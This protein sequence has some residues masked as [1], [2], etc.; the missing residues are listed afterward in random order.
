MIGFLMALAAAQAA[1]APASDEAL[2]R[3][4]IALVQSDPP[5][6]VSAANDWRM[7]GG[8]IHAR[9]CLALAYAAQEQWASAATV[10]EQA[11]RDAEAARDPRQADFWVQAGNAWIAAQDNKK[12][13]TALDAAL[14]TTHLTP[15]LRGETLLDRARASV[16]LNDLAAARADIDKALELVA[17]DPFAWYLSSALALKEGQIARSASDIARAFK[18]APDDANV[19]LQAGTIAGKTG[20]MAAARDFYA[21]AVK[22]D[23][24][25][26]AGRAAAAALGPAE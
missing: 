16:G 23:P 5:K 26:P 14:A 6:A 17:A 13:R 12:A 10:F 15:E 18:L 3:D 1:A 22:A 8:G 2:Y 11:A 19:L 21:R 25:S 24:D 7:R 4:C 9:Q 20:D